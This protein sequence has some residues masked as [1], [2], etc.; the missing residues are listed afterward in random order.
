MRAQASIAIGELGNRAAGRSRRDRPLLTPSDLRTLANVDTCAVQIEV[1]QR[2]A[3][4]GLAFPDERG[5]VAPRPAHVA[6]E[7]VDAG[8][9]LAADEPLR[10]R[11]LPVEHA[12]PRARPFELAGTASPRTLRDRD[13]LRR[14]RCRRGRRRVRESRRRG[15]GAVFA[16]EIV[17]LGVRLLVGH[18]GIIAP[19]PRSLPPS[20]VSREPD[21]GRPDR[22]ARRC[23][24]RRK[25][26]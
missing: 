5:L 13:R 23:R 2:A 7:A 10:M 16:E 22:R 6:I 1:G 14:R 12:C 4:A 11:R 9:Q 20:V 15:K 8:V 3:I 25:A 19:V 18:A 21:C 17:D 24:S 26:R